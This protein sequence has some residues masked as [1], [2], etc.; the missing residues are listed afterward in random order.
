MQKII[1]TLTPQELAVYRLR[2][3]YGEYGFSQYKMSKFEEYD[4]YM[5]NKDFLISDNIITFTDG[6]RLLALK[7]DVTLSIIKNT[8][9]GEGELMK[10]C[11]NEN[12]YRTSAST[13]SFREIMQVGVEC[14]GSVT[15]K[16]IVEVIILAK[17]SL[18]EFAPSFALEI[19][20][21]DIVE[22]VM[23]ASGLG[24]DG[25]KQLLSLLSKK[26]ESEILSL[27]KKEGVSEEIT[28]AIL[29]LSRLYGRV[30]DVAPR[31]DE[32]KKIEGL[33]KAVEHFAGI[34][35]SL[36]K[37]GESEGLY[38]DFS[39]A[40]STKYYNG[41]AMKGYIDGL[42]K[43]VLSGGQYDK[44]LGRMKKQSRGIGF[45]VYLDELEN[46]PT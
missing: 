23:A 41:I 42:P 14:L 21:L 39:V 25:R 45:A 11:Y 13:H 35:D 10:L 26:N 27:C 36:D 12:V 20:D 3:L 34:L 16:E 19:S 37:C 7:P 17:K 38:I 30:K 43:S 5:R 40:E 46:L 1:D 18:G 44:L 2:A 24:T 4:L 9:V 32:L 29:L 31:L 8:R 6:G 15:D 28:E 22:G 33:K